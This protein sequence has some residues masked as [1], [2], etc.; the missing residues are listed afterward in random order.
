MRET[1]PGRFESHLSEDPYAPAVVV[2]GDL[3]RVRRW[4]R[5]A[6]EHRALKVATFCAAH[7]VAADARV[8]V[9]T[10]DPVDA[11]ACAYFVLAT[12]RALAVAEEADLVLDAEALASPFGIDPEYALCA[13]ASPEDPASYAPERLLHDELAERVEV[14]RSTGLG[15]DLDAV[16][17]ALWRGTP[18]RVDDA[19]TAESTAA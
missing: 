14:A 15:R 17:D 2:Y 8:C 4:T 7:G 12:G 18:F 16:L 11:M 5:A 9:S 10:A 1:I 13:V 6:I 3:G 19:R